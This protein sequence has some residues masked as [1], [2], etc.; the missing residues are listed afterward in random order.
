MRRILF[1]TASITLLLCSIY[2][3]AQQHDGQ[4]R[5]Q[6]GNGRM[7]MEGGF[8]TFKG[9]VIDE[10]T[11]LPV[12]YANVILY[13]M[14]D[15]SMVTGGVTDMKGNFSIDKVP[16]GRYYVDFKF[17][18]YK[19][20]RVNNVMI[21]PRQ[22]DLT[23]G[24][25]KL[26]PVSQNMEGVVVTGQK[27]MLQTNL[28]KKVINVDRNI[29]AEGGTALDI[30]RTI[31]SV[32]VDVQ[33]NV[34]LRGSTNLTIL[35]DGKPSQITSLD[36]LPASIVQSV[37]VIT[38]PS[39]RYDPDGLSGI[40]NI[41]LKKKKTPGYHGMVNLNAGTGDKYS[42]TI[43]MNIRQGKF[44]YFGNFDYRHFHSTGSSITNLLY[45]TND[46][47]SDSEKDNRDGLSNNFRGG[48]DYFINPKNT[49]S[50]AGSINV[51]DFNESN[52]AITLFN[53]NPFS[54]Q[55]SSEKN[56]MNGKELTVNYKKTFDTPGEELSAD[57]LYSAY[58]RN[59]D[60]NI[61]RTDN[62]LHNDKSNTD[63]INNS[64]TFQAD[65]VKPIGNGGRLE[66]GLK[67]IVRKQDANYTFSTFLTSTNEWKDTAN[68]S[69]Q[70]TFNDQ[71]YAGYAIYS[72]TIGPISYQGGI[73]VEDQLKKI[74]QRTQNKTVNIS[75]FNYFPSAHVKWDVNKTNAF[76]ISYSKRVNRPSGRV[77]NP[78]INV[79]NIYNVNYGNPYLKPEFTSSYEL[80]HSL[81]FEKANINTTLFYRRTTDKITQITTR[82]P[83]PTIDQ[84]TLKSTYTNLAS[85]ST[86]GV[87]VVATQTFTNW[88]K[89]NGSFSFFKANL[90]TY[91]YTYRYNYKDTTISYSASQSNSWTA[92]MTASFNI[93]KNLELQLNG[94]YR[95]PV[96]TGIS[97]GGDRGP[98]GPGGGGGGNAQGKSK[99]IYWLDL[100]LR[101][102]ILKNKA[103]LTL[104]VSDVFNT[105][106]FKS[107][108]YGSDFTTYQ[109]M[110]QESQVIFLGFSY[111][112]NDYKQ[113]RDVKIDD[114]SDM[115]N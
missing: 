115:D 29:S 97:G 46:L 52:N 110:R 70:F 12:E 107:N 41:V 15:S 37:E 99:E 50:L 4:Q 33:G 96:I 22:P 100:G 45:S 48:I 87:E 13:K 81:N 38:N 42:G 84:D 9:S 103:T 113:R 66:T 55:N 86:L 101:Y 60:Q 93:T 26:T 82:Y 5:M 63:G 92:K 71:I 61:F 83:G 59:S 34:S 7:S 94:N 10:T 104:R 85:G 114:S 89:A 17:I 102:N 105:R 21:N 53:T 44:N 67:G 25:V 109:E 31:P 27:S 51:R 90:D 78:F 57:V 28:D 19:N 1:T 68:L 91:K 6:Q 112:I 32:D 74:E 77:L 24:I 73:R 72:N 39:V 76:Q 56:K 20:N 69:N 58:D 54:T 80:G 47:K 8:G 40:L 106:S 23:L 108:T 64:L 88:F 65:F 95:S 79:E 43:N 36:E 75:L 2:T 3:T 30:M 14:R 16:F 18:G 11:N 98:G 49:L 62:I 111:R 35:V